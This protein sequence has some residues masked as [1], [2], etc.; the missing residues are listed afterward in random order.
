VTLALGRTALR[1]AAVARPSRLG[2]YAVPASD[3]AVAGTCAYLAAGQNGLRIVDVSD[4]RQPREVGVF[5]EPPPQ[6]TVLPI[7]PQRG[8]A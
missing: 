7:V 6:H 1:S 2:T 3:I 5:T 8:S 4:R